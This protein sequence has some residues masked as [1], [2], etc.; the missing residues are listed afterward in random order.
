MYLGQR[1]LKQELDVSL[2]DKHIFILGIADT[3]IL[4]SFWNNTQVRA[5]SE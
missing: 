2:N 3:K 5:D 4:T 1:F